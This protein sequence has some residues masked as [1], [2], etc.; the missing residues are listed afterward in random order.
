[1][2]KNEICLHCENNKKLN[3]DYKRK[4]WNILLVDEDKSNEDVILIVYDE[5]QEKKET[6]SVKIVDFDEKLASFE[7]V[8]KKMI[9]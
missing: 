2:R 3:H 4:S 7:E 5:W 8:I 9:D 1:M 6:N